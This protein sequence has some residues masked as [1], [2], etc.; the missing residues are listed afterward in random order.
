MKRILFLSLIIVCAGQMMSAHTG[1]NERPKLVVGIVVDQMRWDYLSRYYDQFKED[2][3]KRLIEEGYSCD[4]CLIN[5]LPTVTSIGH[6]SVYTGTTPAMHGICGNDFFLDDEPVSCVGDTT[7]NTV[8]SDSN[9]GQCSPRMLLSTT[10]GDQLRMGNSSI[11]LANT[12][13]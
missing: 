8:G 7:V 2:G 13:N 9:K 1:F 12:S 10:I 11:R 4:N 5:Y 6:T 3:F